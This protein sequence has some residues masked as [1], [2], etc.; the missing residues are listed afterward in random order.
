MDEDPLEVWRYLQRFAEVTGQRVK[1]SPSA[2][3]GCEQALADF[4]DAIK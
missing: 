2:K 4:M 1:I 3:P